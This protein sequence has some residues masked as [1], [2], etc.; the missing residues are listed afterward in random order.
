MAYKIKSKPLKERTIPKTPKSFFEKIGKENGM[1]GN[2]LRDFVKFMQLRLPYE[3]DPHY[4]AEWCGRFKSGKEWFYGDT[5]STEIMMKVNPTYYKKFLADLDKEERRFEKARGFRD[6][7][8][9]FIS[10]LAGKSKHA[11]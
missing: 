6:T 4:T 11:R 7:S 3:S 2:Q 1:E 5:Q 10:D 9:S 8:M